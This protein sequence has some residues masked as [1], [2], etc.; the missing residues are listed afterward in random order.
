[1]MTIEKGNDKTD[2]EGKKPGN[3]YSNFHMFSIRH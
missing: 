1:M 2:T 3:H